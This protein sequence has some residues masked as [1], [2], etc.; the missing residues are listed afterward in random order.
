M[1]TAAPL[2]ELLAE[3]ESNFSIWKNEAEHDPFLILR[4]AQQ[5][6]WPIA[7][8]HSFRFFHFDVAPKNIFIRRVG[9]KPH[10]ILGDL[11]V[12]QTVPQSDDPAIA[13]MKDIFIGG[14]REYTPEL[15]HKY[16]NFKEEKLVPA[17][18]LARNAVYWDVYAA[19]ATV[20]E[21]MIEKWGLSDHRDLVATKILCRRAKNIDEKFDALRLTNE[22]ERLLP[23]QV[24]TA[25]VQELS[26]DAF[27]KRTYVQIPLYSVSLSERVQEIT[28]HPVFSRLQRVPQFLLGRTVFPG[29][30]HSRYEHA[31]GTYA[32]G[33]R[34]LIKLLANPQFRV[35]FSK[36]E[37]EEALVAILLSK[38]VSFVFD[39]TFFELFLSN[40][41]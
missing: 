9:G 1:L 11:G 29:G 39:Y 6:C 21:E 38:L 3:E 40:A 28:N 14:T 30:V 36:K 37:L 10:L 4:M 27:G 7:Y 32:L 5:L 41:H 35:D 17:K 18:L 24:L 2:L 16:L 19:I 23:A 26:S 13:T 8:L 25:G 22:L 12:G 31:L 15:L 34:Y 33:Q 20:L